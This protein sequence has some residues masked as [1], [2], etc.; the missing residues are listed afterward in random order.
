MRS[1]ASAEAALGRGDEND[2]ALLVTSL[3]LPNLD[4]IALA[5]LT[6][7]RAGPLPIILMA[8]YDDVAPALRAV[9]D[10]TVSAFV[11]LPCTQATLTA[12][13]AEVLEASRRRAHRQRSLRATLD[14]LHGDTR[15]RRP[16]AIPERDT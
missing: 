3:S 11:A 12:A 7:A 10:M 16:N 2:V 6:S 15:T 8:S 9:R 1:F 14:N 4:G 13:V 5:R